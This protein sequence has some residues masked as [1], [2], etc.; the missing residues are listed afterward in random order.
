[1]LSKFDRN[2]RILKGNEIEFKY[3]GATCRLEVRKSEDDLD[4]TAISKLRASIQNA[5]CD[6]EIISAD[7]ESIVDELKGVDSELYLLQ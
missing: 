1:M 3:N 2:T 6:I 5:I 4:D 7:A